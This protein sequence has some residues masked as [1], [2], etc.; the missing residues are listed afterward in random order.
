LGL[1]GVS[2]VRTEGTRTL[3]EL[4]EGAD[5]QAVLAAALGTGPVREFR[6]DRPSLA[7]LF[8]HVIS[9]EVAA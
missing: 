3:L 2:P 1:A 7:E 8:R 9:E 4:D 5:D 6:P